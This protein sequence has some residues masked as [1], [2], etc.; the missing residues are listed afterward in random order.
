MEIIVSPNPELVLYFGFQGRHKDKKYRL[1]KFCLI[2]DFINGKLIHNHFTGSFIF[3]TNSEFERIYDMENTEPWHKFLYDSWFLVEE[4]FNE[5]AAINEFRTKHRVPVDDFY[6]EEIESYTILPTTGCNARCFYCYERDMSKSTMTEETAE[7]VVQYMLKK[8]K[9]PKQAIR[10]RWFGGEPM[11]N[12]KIIRYICR[13]LEESGRN[14]F[15][16]MNSNGYLFTEKIAQEA[17]DDWKLN[18]IQITL[19]GTEDIYNKAKNYVYK[20]QNEV[21][22]FKKV[23]DNIGFLTSRGINVTIRMNVDMYNAEDLKELVREIHLRFPEHNNL[24]VYAYPIFEDKDTV[25]DDAAR[26]AVYQKIIEIEEVMAENGFVNGSPMSEGIRGQ[27]CM[28][29]NG[30]NV[31]ISPNGDLG[32]CEHYIDTDFW[33]HI[34]DDSNEKRNWDIIYEWRE[35]MPKLDI[36]EDCCYFPSC[37]RT[38]K[39]QDLHD[40]HKWHKEFNIRHSAQDMVYSYKRWMDEQRQ[41]KRNAEQKNNCQGGT[42]RTPQQN[43]QMRQ[44]ANSLPSLSEPPKNKIINGK[45][46]N[47]DETFEQVSTKSTLGTKLKNLFKL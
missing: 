15:S 4:D 35:Y 14:F 20:N 38:R 43:N 37:I 45:V 12:M 17:R 26:E 24:G 31:T 47:D 22:P 8:A 23:I 46:V 6:L 18:N 9:N 19:D 10:L 34:D 44:A 30:R 7:K 33:G 32:L 3:M 2:E 42:C 41:M 28:V 11:V 29:D 40:C 39:C 27:H 36:C 5:H 16:S 21:S 1:N 25:R 13:R